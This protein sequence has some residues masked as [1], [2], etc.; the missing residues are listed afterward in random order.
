MPPHDH[1]H[2]LPFPYLASW[3][4]A[5]RLCGVDVL[6]KFE[7]YGAVLDLVQPARNRLQPNLLLQVF[8]SCTRSATRGHFPLVLGQ[9]LSLDHP[10]A[11]QTFL[12]TCPTIREALKLIDWAEALLPPGFKISLVESEEEAWLMFEQPFPNSQEPPLRYITESLMA[13]ISKIGT[14]L[15]G[16]ALPL[17]AVHFMHDRPAYHD[18]YSRHF[19]VEP[20]YNQSRNAIY[21]STTLLDKPLAGA[22]IDINTQAL[23]ILQDHSLSEVSQPLF[24]QMVVEALTQHPHFFSSGLEE[25]ANF[26]EMSP[27]TFQRKLNKEG[28][29]YS[30]LIRTA[31]CSMATRWLAETQMDVNTISTKLGY[32]SR[33]A[34]TNA[35]KQWTG[36]TPSD[37]RQRLKG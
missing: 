6:S 26:F 35:F 8:N 34:F 18:E 31:Q 11:A 27:R 32:Q 17:L 5:G 20:R 2:A 12:V 22:R 4:S 28:R 21:F 19:H 33:R 13:V 24:S 30:D 7:K 1:L 25:I 14:Y 37:Y 9:H 36:A 29:G 16:N 10:P 15:H 3:I 23:K